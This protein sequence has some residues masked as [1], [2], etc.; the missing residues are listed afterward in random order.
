MA[1]AAGLAVAGTVVGLRLGSG[2]TERGEAV[3]V[4][5]ASQPFPDNFFPV[6][7]A[8]ASLSTTQLVVQVLPGPF[9][10]RPDLTVVRDED[11]LTSE[12]TSS[13]VGGRQI[14]TYRLNRQARWSDG[15]PI[16]AGDFA[17]SWRIQRSADSA[18]GGC[19]AILSTVGYDQIASVK[20]AD[21]GRTVVVTFSRPFADWKGLFAPVFPAHLMDSGDPAKSCA[22]M[23]RGWPAAGGVPV[24]G[25]PWKIDQA[26]V[27]PGKKT[28]SLTPNRAY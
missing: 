5:G 24:S 23:K 1:I 8:G 13:L 6:I 10:L 7:G 3:V 22:T 17:F 12:P 2:D 14:V 21:S 4:W 11:L 15:H 19:P 26:D 18:R 28:V 16:D 9:R 25:G 20:G 27:N